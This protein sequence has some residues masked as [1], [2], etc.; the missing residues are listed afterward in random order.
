MPC[1]ASKLLDFKVLCSFE[2][3]FFRSGA[4]IKIAQCWRITRFFYGS[5]AEKMVSK[6][7]LPYA[8]AAKHYG[9][10]LWRQ[11]CILG[12]IAKDGKGDGAKEGQKIKN[13]FP[14]AHLAFAAPDKYHHSVE[15]NH[16]QK[17]QQA[18]NQ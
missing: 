4:I 5:W 7:I 16:H 8:R 3:Q 9:I 17:G 1:F 10:F 12:H 18:K 6:P 13:R 14:F 11:K 2:T 15:G